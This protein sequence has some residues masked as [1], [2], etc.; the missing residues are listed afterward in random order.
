M[1]VGRGRHSH[2][3]ER[4]AARRSEPGTLGPRRS[5]PRR[6][7]RG[8]RRPADGQA[9]GDA[10]AHHLAVRYLT[11]DVSPWLNGTYTEAT[12]RELFAAT[13]QLVRLAGA[14]P[15]G[16]SDV[17]YQAIAREEPLA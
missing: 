1:T 14:L 11:D 17:R 6:C 3:A 9:L 10:H 15:F 8:R 2:A 13:S 12:G 5:R 7:R 16:R 4:H